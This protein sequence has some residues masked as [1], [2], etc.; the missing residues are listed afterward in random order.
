MARSV[1]TSYSRR[2]R[3]TAQQLGLTGA[4]GLPAT[5]R[6][7]GCW[8][9]PRPAP[10]GRDAG[11][12]AEP[13]GRAVPCRAIA[14]EAGRTLPLGSAPP[15]RGQLP[16]G[17]APGRREGSRGRGGAGGLRPGRTTRGGRALIRRGRGAPGG[18]APPRRRGCRGA[19]GL[20]APH[21]SSRPV[22]SRCPPDG[23]PPRDRSRG[24]HAGRVRGRPKPRRTTGAGE[25][26]GARPPVPARAPHSP[27][28]ARRG[29]AAGPPHA[30]PGGGGPA[31]RRRGAGGSAR[32]AGRRAA[33]GGA[34]R[35]S[36]PRGAG[37]RGTSKP[38]A[39]PRRRRRSR[40]AG[41]Q[42]VP[43]A[44]DAVRAALRVTRRLLPLCDRKNAT[45][46]ETNKQTNPP[47][48]TAA[49]R[50]LHLAELPPGA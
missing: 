19:L 27:A 35:P 26:R 31:G 39:L 38:G 24:T 5:A 28:A 45:G 8:L 46:R 33:G 47:A 2:G 30:S 34:Q 3:S 15:G 10:R 42:S 18:P 22:P 12:P 13:S 17:G 43:R 37:I 16:A 11:S 25:P 40:T 23:T 9:A 32:L 48:P 4:T 50:A 44:S 41:G 20:R 7:S 29:P 1:Q 14:R 49:N 21:G 6:R 36:L